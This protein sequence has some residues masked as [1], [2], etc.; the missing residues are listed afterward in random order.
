[1]KEILARVE[2]E[3]PYLPP[4]EKPERPAFGFAAALNRSQTTLVRRRREAVALPTP[5]RPKP[6][7]TIIDAQRRDD[8]AGE[9]SSAPDSGN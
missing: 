4:N 8:P 7:I 5:N 2:A 1:V 6:E 3:H 9:Q